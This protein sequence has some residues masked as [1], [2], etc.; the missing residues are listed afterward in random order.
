MG[1]SDFSSE[2]TVIAADIPATIATPVTTISGAERTFVTVTWTAPYNGGSEVT[3]LNIFIRGSDLT[4]YHKELTSCDGSNPAIISAASCT[5]PIATLM[6]APFNLPWGSSIYVKLTATN[7]QGTTPESPVG[8]GATILTFPDSPINFQNVPTI[9]NGYQIGLTWTK[10]VGEGG[11][12]V[13][14][15]R[16]WYDQAANNWKVLQSNIV[17]TSLTV[18]TLTMGT[19]YKFKVESRNAFG[20]SVLFSNEISVL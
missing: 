9:T 19:E 7:I 13:I 3:S 4:T 12:P 10:G 16:V 2:I 17:A 14:D 5:I 8:N 18:T 20:Y 11:T 15:Y 6:A 1:F